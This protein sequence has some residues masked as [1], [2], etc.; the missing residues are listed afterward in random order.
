MNPS[1]TTSV[2][3]ADTLCLKPHSSRVR[4]NK[5][6]EGGRRDERAR[7]LHNGPCY[8]VSHDADGSLMGEME[9]GARR[10]RPDR[11]VGNAGGVQKVSTNWVTAALGAERMPATVGAAATPT[12]TGTS[13]IR[14]AAAKG[15]AAAPMLEATGEKATA[16]SEGGE[17]AP[18]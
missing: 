8:G 3:C 5:N 1:S 10:D 15:L 13:E 18:T 2:P 7:S 9:S 6:G 16:A 17:A 11:C 4:H 12:S 14:M